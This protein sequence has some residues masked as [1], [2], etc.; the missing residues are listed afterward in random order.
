MVQRVISLF[1]AVTTLSVYLW[2]QLQPSDAL[3]LFATANMLINLGLIGLAAVL[4]KLS[5]A[6][7]FHK[8]WTYTLAMG[9]AIGCLAISA[10]GLL[11]AG[12]SY[13]IFSAFG[14]L[15]FLLLAEAGIVLSISS[16]T[17]KH[18]TR[19]Q[20]PSLKMPHFPIPKPA[21]MVPRSAFHSLKHFRF[22]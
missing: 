7:R 19:L 15:D 18:P 17:Y 12:L 10:L 6:D 8:S 1:M 3:F 4:V 22:S 20:M 16:L 9:G 5:F 14:P 13:K 11:T 21:L 2:S